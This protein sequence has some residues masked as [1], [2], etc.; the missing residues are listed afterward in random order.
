MIQTDKKTAAQTPNIKQVFHIEANAQAFSTLLDKIY[1][2][3]I[4]AVVRETISNAWDSH[5]QAGKKD[6]PF[7][8][9]MPNL[10]E[11]YFSVRD[12]GVSMSKQ[13]VY[14]IYTTLFASSK[15]NTNEAVGAFGL[16]CKAPFCYVDIFTVTVWFNG[17]ETVYSMFL[18]AG[19]PSIIEVSECLSDEEQG[20]EVKLVVRECDFVHFATEIGKMQKSVLPLTMNGL[21]YD[22]SLNDGLVTLNGEG[23]SVSVGSWTSRGGVSIKQGCVIYLTDI[24]KYQRTVILQVPIAT[25]N[26]TA[27]RESI[28]FDAITDTNI[29]TYLDKATDLIEK[30]IN[31]LFEAARKLLPIAASKEIC[32]LVAFYGNSHVF[33]ADKDHLDEINVWEQ[34][35]ENVSVVTDSGYKKAKQITDATHIDFRKSHLW[36]SY[37]ELKG[38]ITFAKKT[39]SSSHLLIKFKPN[40]EQ[41]FLKAVGFDGVLPT[42]KSI[43]EIDDDVPQESGGYVRMYWK[44]F[45]DSKASEPSN[46]SVWIRKEEKHELDNIQFRDDIEC[47]PVYILSARDSKTANPDYHYTK[48][49]NER[50]AKKVDTLKQIY[51]QNWF[52]KE[53]QKLCTKQTWY[54]LQYNA[55]FRAPGRVNARFVEA[56]V[57]E[58]DRLAIEKQAN[59]DA[60]AFVKKYPLIINFTPEAY[61]ASI[62]KESK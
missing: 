62:D 10:L 4:G 8:V 11:P 34:Y 37:T 24:Q 17:V 40:M 51:Y 54:V 35:I 7:D 32:N 58:H 19:V 25:C 23:F 45:Y 27:S 3:K 48:V 47:G 39:L 29:K 59:D 42:L 16:G 41:V 38:Y 13:D 6:V 56:V 5:M 14:D 1:S 18:D 36:V 20:L 21:V 55:L 22:D 9:H 30:H 26:V 53:I 28:S 2:N 31:G 15:R 46:T 43:K 52:S 61:M 33:T 44:T 49:F 12:Y 50:S 57:P 60:V